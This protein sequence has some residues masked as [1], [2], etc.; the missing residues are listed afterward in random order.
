[1]LQLQLRTSLLAIA[2]VADIMDAVRS[3][4]AKQ[5][6]WAGNLTEFFDALDP[7]S[8]EDAGPS[9]EDAGPS[10][11]EQ[12][13]GAAASK[14]SALGE[15]RA[16]VLAPPSQLA[17]PLLVSPSPP[18]PSPPLRPPPSS[19]ADGV[20]VAA[21]SSASA[22]VAAGLAAKCPKPNEGVLYERNSGKKLAL[23]AILRDRSCVSATWEQ[24][25]PQLNSAQETLEEGKGTLQI[26][27]RSGRERELDA[28]IGSLTGNVA[29]KVAVAANSSASAPVAA[30]L[31][32][33]CPNKGGLDQRNSAE[34]SVLMRDASSLSVV[35][36][37]PQSDNAQGTL[38]QRPD[39]TA[40]TSVLETAVIDAD[41]G[42]LTGNWGARVGAKKSAE[43]REVQQKY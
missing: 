35:E 39:N 40:V 29:D 16:A 13:A 31:V 14:N 12:P 20:A 32:A 26:R 5:K 10:K 4:D 19:V 15:G 2:V 41:I 22:P 1:L 36:A 17:E 6:H 27:R 30:G 7:P 28:D 37:D 11:E 3:G 8:E 34:R 21:N 18:P 42:I 38:E 23:S 24:P 9:E 43:E 25:D 33:C